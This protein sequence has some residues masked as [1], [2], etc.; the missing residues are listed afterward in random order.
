MTTP[1]YFKL[2]LKALL[3]EDGNEFSYYDFDVKDEDDLEWP[4][5][6]GVKLKGPPTE[7]LK[8]AVD[9]DNED[10]GDFADFVL[11]PIP[12]VSQRFRDALDAAGANNV[13]Y[14]PVAIEGADQFDEFPTYFAANIVGKIAAADK[15]ASQYTEAFGGPGADL[16]DKLVLDPKLSTDLPIFILAENLS[17]VI[18]SEKVKTQAEA[19]GV[20]TLRFIP[21]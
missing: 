5:M 10:A 18:V 6:H 15:S 2:T 20:D 8:L 17:M 12:M 9:L 11:G 4:W 21:L 13:D 16:F 1:K 7:A 14:Y 19:L 3:D